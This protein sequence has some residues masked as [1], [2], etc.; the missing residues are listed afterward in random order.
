MQYNPGANAEVVDQTIVSPIETQVNGVKR[1]LYM[2]STSANDGSAT[3]NITF[4]IGSD[5]DL[6]TV[7][8]QNRV[9]IATPQLPE[10]VKRQGVSTKEQSTN[11]LMIVNIFSPKN[12][13]PE[14]FLN[15]YTLLSIRDEIA[16]IL[17]LGMPIFSVICHIQCEYG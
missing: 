11:M 13:Y 3:I 1:M 16:R 2:S 15:N 9:S 7:N 8:S 14:L 4:E 5:G 10:E 17:G 12:S 6:N